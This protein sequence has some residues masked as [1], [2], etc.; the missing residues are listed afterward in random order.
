MDLCTVKHEGVLHVSTRRYVPLPTGPKHNGPN[1]YITRNIAPTRRMNTYIISP[2]SSATHIYRRTRLPLSRTLT[3]SPP[4]ALS[5]SSDV[6]VLLLGVVLAALYLFRDQIFSSSPK[7][8]TTAV[9]VKETNGQGN[10]RDFVAK[11]KAG[12]RRS[13]LPFSSILINIL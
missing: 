4:M 11:M 13:L 1:A 7:P 10:P 2:A 6:L 8:K 9:P 5:L 3:I 12:V